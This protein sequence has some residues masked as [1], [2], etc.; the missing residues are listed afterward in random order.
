MNGPSPKDLVT[1]ILSVSRETEWIEFKL[2]N[3][4]PTE[5]GKNISAISNAATLHHKPV[6]FIVWGIDNT[7]GQPVG[8]DFDPSR[9][10]VGGEELENWLSHHLHPRVNFTI[11]TAK[12]PKG[13]ALIIF[14]VHPCRHTPVRFDDFDY[15]RVGSYTKKLRDYPEKERALWS[16]LE[17][18]HFESSTAAH[19]LDSDEVLSLIDYP[20]YFEMAGQRLPT[21]KSGI[22]GKLEREK[23]VAAGAY[24]RWS[25][26]NLGAILFAKKLTD[27]DMLSRKVVRVIIYRSKNRTETIKEQLGVKGYA[28]GFSGLMAYVNDQ[29]PRNEQIGQALRR[30]VRMY[31]EVAIR[32]LVANALI[33][34][35]FSFTGDSPIIEIFPDRIEITNS[36]VPLISTDRFIDEPPRS[37]NESLAALMR[38]LN[39]CEERGSG[40]D[41]VILNVE[42]YQLPAPEFL[43]TE[44]HTKVI[45]Y[46]H[47]KLSEMD[48]GDKVRACY[49]HACLQ[50]V[51]NEKMTNTTLRKRF[52]LDERNAAIA[53]RILGDTIKA[54]LIKLDDPANTSRKHARYLPYWA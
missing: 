23:L 44:S 40:I 22:L 5:I 25:V 11:H 54:R 31:P 36:G 6:G 29:L 4:D 52:A 2:N 1:Q 15:I 26:T 21:N 18:A 47:R 43:V 17:K 46:A 8:T 10:K 37:R 38:R 32:E 48:R 50:Y 34:Q 9:Q 14:E 7:S 51:S 3:A 19:E 41:K 33:H 53:S 27:F 30:D 20:T 13:A 45:L 12:T 49:Q 35:D 28:A 42:L 39:I 16:I 24:G